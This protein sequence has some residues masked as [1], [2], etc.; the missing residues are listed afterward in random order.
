MVES[1]EKRYLLD[2]APNELRELMIEW[3]EP[4][5]RSKQISNW[6]FHRYVKSVDEM[7]DL[8]LPL[9]ARLS[10]ESEL[11]RLEPIRVLRSK[12][13]HTIKYLF[14]LP[15]GARIESVRMN[16]ERRRTAC[17]STQVGCGIGCVFCATGRMGLTRNLTSGEI[18]EQVLHIAA[19]MV[20][21]KD[22]RGLTHVVFMGM[23]EPFANYDNT[24]K[25][26]RCLTSS[27]GFGLGARRIT[28]STVGLVPGIRK[29]SREALQVNLSVSL[30]AATDELR[31]RLIPVNRRYPLRKLIRSIRD[32]IDQT[33]RR[34][35]FEWA[36]IDGVNDTKAELNSLVSLV[37]G[38]MCHVN[39]IPVNPVEGYPKSASQRNAVHAFR[40]G[41][42]RAGIPATV[43]MRRGVD[44]NAGCGQLCALDQEME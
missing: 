11:T 25:A 2:Y 16:Y 28:V 7:T 33:R 40:V 10:R 23:G 6:I 14:A 29:F 13:T 24:M 34:V 36:L 20:G 1:P 27:D 37:R 42:E 5:F 26:I 35:T 43:R 32:Y 3:G 39:L 21:S 41:L 8:S 22:R 30:H 15:D 38:L 18:V 9:R 31:N 44:I 4:P 17:V 12:D 19:E